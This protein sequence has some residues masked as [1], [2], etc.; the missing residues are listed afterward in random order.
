[1]EYLIQNSLIFVIV[2]SM[3]TPVAPSLI[4]DLFEIKEM[5]EVKDNFINEI[6]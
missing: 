4:L 1:M 5:K 2:Q 3:K 6:K